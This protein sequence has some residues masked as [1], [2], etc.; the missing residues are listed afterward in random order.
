ML[1]VNRAT[2]LDEISAE[3][4]RF[5]RSHDHEE[6]VDYRI[7]LSQTLALFF[8]RMIAD[9]TPAGLMDSVMTAVPKMQKSGD[10]P[11]PAIPDDT[12]GVT[13]HN[14][15]AKAWRDADRRPLHAYVRNGENHQPHPGGLYAW[16][17]R[18]A[19][20]FHAL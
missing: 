11:D 8:D 12:R 7:R 1:K 13:V 20:C 16:P 2:G 17:L 15:L 18:G 10:L 9:G 3:A 5:I 4:M 19:L 6:T 14:T